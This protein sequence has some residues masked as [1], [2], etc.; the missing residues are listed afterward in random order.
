M[1][2]RKIKDIDASVELLKDRK[3]QQKLLFLFFYMAGLISLTIGLCFMPTIYDDMFFAAGI[4]GLILGAYFL[5]IYL[6][7]STLIFIR[8]N[9]MTED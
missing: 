4:G 7:I 6:H 9:I 8:V 2:D 5:V 1:L 3:Q